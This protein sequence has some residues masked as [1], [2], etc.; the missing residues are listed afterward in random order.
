MKGRN[1]INLSQRIIGVTGGGLAV[2]CKHC[3]NMFGLNWP[4]LL[5]QGVLL[6]GFFELSKGIFNKENINNK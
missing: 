3:V 2:H 5:C 1:K 6:C 4:H